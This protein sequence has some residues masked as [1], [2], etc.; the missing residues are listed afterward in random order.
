MMMAPTASAPIT[1]AAMLSSGP[2]RTF[3]LTPPRSPRSP[4]C[5]WPALRPEPARGAGAGGKRL[6]ETRGA[7]ATSA[8]D[9][10]GLEPRAAGA[11]PLGEA[12]G[13]RPLGGGADGMRALG[14]AAGM[15]ALGA[16]AG[17]R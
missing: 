6:L 1:P 17:M 11:R 9:I 4:R 8:G 12:T 7:G 3:F 5:D 16:A 2:P 14:E 10:D 15:L 13:A